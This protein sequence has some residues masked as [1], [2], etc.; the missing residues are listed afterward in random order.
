[1]F[2]L[3][4]QVRNTVAQFDF[5]GKGEALHIAGRAAA[6]PVLV[7]AINEEFVFYSIMAT[8]LTIVV[9]ALLLQRFWGIAITAVS[10]VLGLIFFM[11]I[12]GATGKPLD[13]MSPLFPTLMIVVGMS[14]VIHILSKY[15]DE[16]NKG[17]NK[18]KALKIT[19]REIGV[20]TLLT[21]VTTAVGFLS[22]YTANIVAIKSFGLYAALGVMVAYLTVL[23][24]TTAIIIKFRPQQLANLKQHSH[25]WN[26]LMLKNYQLVRDHKKMILGI[27]LFILVVCFFGISKISTNSVLLDDMPINNTIRSDFQFFEEHL[28]GVRTFEMAIL[29]QD[30]HQ[31]DGLSV[32]QEVE[33]LETFLQTIPEIGTLYSP[34][35]L[36]KSLHKSNNGNRFSFY[37]LPENEQIIK[38]YTRQIKK[39]NKGKSAGFAN[40]LIS[41][42]KKHGRMAGNIVDVGSD[43]IKAIHERIDTWIAA[44]IRADVVQFRITGTGLLVDK[45]HTYLRESLFTGLGLAFLVVSL[46]MALL[47]RNVKMVFISLIPNVFPL[48][49]AG[50]IMGF[51]GISLKASTAIIFTIAF[52]IAV[53]DTIHF[54][55]KFKLQLDKGSTIDTAIRTTFL[56]TGKALCLTTIILFIGFMTM[57]S[58][59]FSAT[60]Y[61]G[62]LVSITLV[63]A[64]IAD[65][66]LLPACIYLIFRT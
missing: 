10:V 22:L 57:I 13:V 37:Q 43:N 25:F 60:F 12:L 32:L 18:R 39:A 33:K 29:A 23:F 20:A 41:E 27:S 59:T 35:M 55:S 44:N 61:V 5:S 50:A 56:E 30:N 9:M 49:V 54:L 14:D 2:A 7:N 16:I 26:R 62:L 4:E 36:Y 1:M 48:L 28:S 31:M 45:N 19:I 58:S 47:F 42:D 40:R 46:I 53:D 8:L 3:N 52:G 64:L 15:L 38:K 17:K 51:S 63:T 34:V 24:F 21:S 66:F 11:G 6:T 65:L